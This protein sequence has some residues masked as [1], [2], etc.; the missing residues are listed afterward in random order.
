[1]VVLGRRSRLL[2]GRDV[3]MA[4]T[5]HT[6]AVL[7]V[8]LTGVLAPGRLMA[9]TVEMAVL[10]IHVVDYAHVPAGEM[11]HAQAEV[12]RIY[13]TAGV[14]VQWAAA[15]ITSPESSTARHVRIVLLCRDMAER[16]IAT[17]H[18]ADGTLGQAS[19]P[20]GRAYVF[21]D[22]VVGAAVQQRQDFTRVFGRV[23]AHEVG[24]LLL[25]Y[26]SHSPHGIMQAELDGRVN[27]NGRF[28]PAQ[29]AAIHLTLA[30]ANPG[31]GAA[32]RVGVS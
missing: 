10:V 8:L 5:R 16:K 19:G 24:H 23:M 31:D 9:A 18:V 6:L 3:T 29:V 1:M 15:E 22:R 2:N 26:G 17:D 4:N 25:P 32:S 13:A 14:S 27:A 28:T 30:A 21:Y 11:S 12:T 7:T 20:T